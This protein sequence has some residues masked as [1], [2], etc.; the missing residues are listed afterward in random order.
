VFYIFY[1][2][3]FD[4]LW[5]FNNIP[6]TI[7]L[8]DSYSY[9]FFVKQFHPSSKKNNHSFLFRLADLFLKHFLHKFFNDDLIF[10]EYDW[11][12]SKRIFKK[13][14]TETKKRHMCR[15]HY[16]KETK[17]RMSFYEL[18]S[19]FSYIIPGRMC[20]RGTKKILRVYPT[21]WKK[22]SKERRTFSPKMLFLSSR[23]DDGL[24]HDEEIFRRNWYFL[25]Y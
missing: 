8:N 7:S 23:L 1:I 24:I 3:L 9:C 17:T 6:F 21:P 16:C 14:E 11:L 13:E 15:H 12:V 19:I 5:Q 25:T 18:F 22:L 2:K 10:V 4:F 20:G